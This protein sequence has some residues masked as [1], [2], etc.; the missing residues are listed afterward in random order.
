M[1]SRLPA[2]IQRSGGT[3][4]D[5]PTSDRY[6]RKP[7]KGRNMGKRCAGEGLIRKRKDGRWEARVMDGFQDDGRPNKRC[8]YGKTQKE[9]REK[10]QQFQE[11]K[12]AGLNTY[13]NYNFEDW[14]DI[15]FDGHKD[16][17]SLT[18]QESYGYTLRVLK[19]AFSNRKLSSIR[20]YDVEQFLKR[21][22]KD[23]QSDSRVT[24]CRGMLYQIFNKAEA[25]DIIRKNPVRFAE[26]M[27]HKGQKKRKE[28]FTA[29]EV[30]RL[31][32]K[33]PYDRMGYSIRLLL[34]TG[35]R[36]QELLALE[37]RHIAE[38]GSVI[39]IQQ[40]INMVKGKGIVGTPKSST[41]YREVPV[42]A[43]LRYCAM[44]LR[45]T[46]FKYIWEAGI[47]NQPC[48][49]SYFRKKFKEALEEVGEVQILTPHCCRHTFV[50]QMQ[51]LGVSMETIQGLVGH[52]DIDMTE[53]YLHLQES[54]RQDAIGRFAKRFADAQAT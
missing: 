48:N 14:A 18:T 37:P 9:V 12:T 39:Q 19:D 25:N 32:E 23:G 36:T 17:I 40:A 35:M 29:A 3:P 1:N 4:P 51:A 31:L 2:K 45:N 22:K 8:F 16:N 6:W 10:L 43:N 13:Q 54:V 47:P 15:W 46:E 42:P 53:H 5:V 38:D 41:S 26:K 27:R 30:A 52:A 34:G 11:Q 49:P 28:A 33:L 20:A 44:A 21:L 50:S 24:Q 7:E